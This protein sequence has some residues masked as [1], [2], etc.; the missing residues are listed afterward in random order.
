MRE[1]KIFIIPFDQK[2]TSFGVQRYILELERRLRQKIQTIPI[3]GPQQFFIPV[4]NHLNKLLFY[5]LKILLCSLKSADGVF[6]FLVPDFCH[7]FPLLKRPTV[8]TFHD[9]YALSPEVNGRLLSKQYYITYKFAARFADFIIVNSER[10]KKEVIDFYPQAENKIKVINLG[11]DDKFIPL[12][13]KSHL[14]KRYYNT[15]CTVVGYLGGL[16]KRKRL[17]KLIVD[18]KTNWKDKNTILAI[19]GK[20]KHENYFRELARN[21]S[22]ILFMG[23]APEQKIVEI[24]NSFD[25]FF[26]PSKDE[27]FGLPILEAT[28]CGIPC[29]V[30]DDASFS[31]E[32]KRFF[33]KVVSVK[34]VKEILP[35]ISLKK[36]NQR[37]RTVKKEFNWEKT[38]EEHIK[39]YNQVV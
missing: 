31:N 22:R 29:F 38:V 6:H 27:G 25:V 36:L 23:P 12:K 19:W 3:R 14:K 24:Y 35:N 34:E 17:D 11:V 13:K 16:H 39:V 7:I 2:T 8:V 26:F 15:E 5:S 21:D 1:M 4:V 32:L 10:T 28:A 37:A 33:N 30:Y 20:G 18:F 9:F